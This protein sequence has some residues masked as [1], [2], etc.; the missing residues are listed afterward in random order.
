M[1][2][3]IPKEIQQLITLCL[4]KF[5][6]GFA[7]QKGAIFGFSDKSCRD[8]TPVLKISDLDKEELNV[9]N[10]VQVHNLGKEHNVELFDWEISIRGKK[11]FEAA[12]QKLVLNKSNDLI[13]N[14]KLIHHTKKNATF[15]WKRDGKNL[16]ISDYALNLSLYFDQSCCVSSLTMA[17]LRNVLNSLKSSTIDSVPQNVQ[18]S[19]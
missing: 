3:K 17:D 5:A 19:W 4:K 11:N 9:L 16:P 2:W 10:T 6:D 14:L 15:H 18:D 13:F 12:S 7:H 1:L 8:T